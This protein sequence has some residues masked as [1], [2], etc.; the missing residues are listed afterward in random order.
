MILRFLLVVL[1]FTALPGSSLAGPEAPAAPAALRPPLPPKGS[2]PDHL[3]SFTVKAEE[4]F[5]RVP[6]VLHRDYPALVDLET[7]RAERAEIR[8]AVYPNETEEAAGGDD[9]AINEAPYRADSAT[10]LPF[11]VS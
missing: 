10:P 9:A 5:V 3:Q 6:A 8:A 1:S 4:I 7:L 11:E 2:H